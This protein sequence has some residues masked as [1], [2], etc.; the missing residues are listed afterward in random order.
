[1][2][3]E[4]QCILLNNREA[5]VMMSVFYGDSEQASEFGRI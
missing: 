5:K 3:L 1:M 2:C 4:S